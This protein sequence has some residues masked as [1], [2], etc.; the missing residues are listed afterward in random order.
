MMTGRRKDKQS[1]ACGFFL[2]SVA[3]GM[4]TLQ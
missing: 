2:L 4:Y 1:A 3:A